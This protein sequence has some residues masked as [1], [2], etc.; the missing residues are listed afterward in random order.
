MKSSDIPT[1]PMIVITAYLRCECD[2]TFRLVV[3]FCNC[4]VL[5]IVFSPGDNIGQVSVIVAG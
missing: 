4:K 2:I 5:F 3:D 1:S